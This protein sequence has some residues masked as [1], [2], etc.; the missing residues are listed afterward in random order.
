ME[1]FKTNAVAPAPSQEDVN[2]HVQSL[3]NTEHAQTKL[4]W[5]VSK[6]KA[7]GGERSAGL[8]ANG[9][10]PKSKSADVVPSSGWT[11]GAET[12]LE[13]SGTQHRRQSKAKS[14]E[15]VVGPRDDQDDQNQATPEAKGRTGNGGTHP[16]HQNQKRNVVSPEPGP[17][18]GQEEPKEVSTSEADGIHMHHQRQ[19]NDENP[20][21]PRTQTGS[22]GTLLHQQNQDAREHTIITVR[23][24]NEPDIPGQYHNPDEKY[25]SPSVDSRTFLDN[26]NGQSSPDPASLSRGEEE[27]HET[28][29]LEQK[30]NSQ[31]SQAQPGTGNGFGGTQPLQSPQNPSQPA[32]PVPRPGSGNSI[33]RKSAWERAEERFQEQEKA[34]ME[35]G[36][37]QAVSV[38]TSNQ[39]DEDEALIMADSGFCNF[40]AFCGALRA[41]KFRNPKLEQLYQ[42]Y[43]FKH[44]QNNL[45]L[46]T[47]LLSILCVVLVIFHYAG[48]S[49]S[50]AKGV[51]LTIVLLGFIALE[52][53]INQSSF[54]HMQLFIVTYIVFALVVVIVTVV[55]IDTKPGTASSE[56]LWCAIFCILVVYMLLPV[57]MRLSLASGLVLAV[58]HVVCTTALHYNQPQLW[59]QVSEASSTR[60]RYLLLNSKK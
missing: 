4:D 11:K 13:P 34:M 20:E 56:G 29:H 14:Y 43:F 42:R 52:I 19:K 18:T 44:N 16:Q 21:D 40:R 51:V 49:S 24:I 60:Y 31:I 8:K 55:T 30:R 47:A 17:E 46:L 53:I 48:G 10:I 37:M 33:N 57:R 22:G 3:D 7:N 15:H 35:R 5:S 1:R 9:G 12:A 38:A 2:T 50:V 28:I 27:D 39:D 45:T 23:S 54:N 58:T 59:K 26:Q 25:S 36:R 32:F 41:K 6:V